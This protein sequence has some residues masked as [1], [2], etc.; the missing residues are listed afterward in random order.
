MSKFLNAPTS[1]TNAIKSTITTDALVFRWFL[2]LISREKA[3][4]D[5]A[6]DGAIYARLKKAVIYQNFCSIVLLIVLLYIFLTKQYIV[7]CAAVIIMFVYFKLLQAIREHV[8]LLSLKIIAKHFK[9]DEADH[10]T[11]YQI[12]ERLANQYHVKSLVMSM[13]SVD[14]IVR[15]ALLFALIFASCIVP[16]TLFPMWGFVLAVYW[17]TFAIINASIVYNHLS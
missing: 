14:I 15:R 2:Y 3:K 8:A 11:L 12:G 9:P 1:S 17:A 4:I 7:L 13:T 5:L 16:L 6:D 10:H